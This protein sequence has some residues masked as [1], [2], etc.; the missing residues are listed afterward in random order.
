M[1]DPDELGLEEV[2]LLAGER[3]VAVDFGAEVSGEDVLDASSDLN[4]L[5]SSF[6]EL[7]PVVKKVISDPECNCVG[8]FAG[9]FDL[10]VLRLVVGVE[11]T[12]ADDVVLLG[13]VNLA[14]EAEGAGSR[15]LSESLHRVAELVVEFVAETVARPFEHLG[16]FLPVGHRDGC[17]GQESLV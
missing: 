14:E 1:G 4:M 8:S 3:R 17:R 13:S 7:D 5:G 2:A 9:S 11:L 12:A 6:R 10:G 15:H 16:H